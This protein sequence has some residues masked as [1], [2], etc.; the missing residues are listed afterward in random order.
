MQKKNT[1]NPFLILENLEVFK[2]HLIVFKLIIVFSEH[3]ACNVFF[4]VLLLFLP[5]HLAL[6]RMHIHV[7]YMKQKLL[8]C[9]WQSNRAV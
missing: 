6:F 4:F 9:D 1:G 5:F 3:A 7:I 2:V 8:D